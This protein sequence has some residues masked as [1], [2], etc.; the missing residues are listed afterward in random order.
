MLGYRGGRQ[1]QQFNELAHA[2]FM[3]AEG[4]QY[5][6]PV[7]VGKCFGGSNEG[8]RGQILEGQRGQI[9]NSE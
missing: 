7:F 8:Q 9:L 6:N 1:S 3:E 5:P 2:Q 4:A